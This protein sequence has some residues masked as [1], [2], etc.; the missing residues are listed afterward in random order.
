MSEQF[1]GDYAPGLYDEEKRYYLLQAQ[2][3]ATLTDAELR[4]MHYISNTYA[5]RIIQ[6]QIGDCSIN[7]GF[8]IVENTD[9]SNNFKIT[10]G[11]DT[12]DN[13]GV[14]FLKGYRLF[15]KDDITYKGQD[16][17]G[18]I[19]D[20]GYTETI[21]SPLTTPTGTVN[22]L[23]AVDVAGGNIVSCGGLET[24]IKSSD[25]GQNWGVKVSG[26]VTLFDIDMA[27]SSTGFAV[28]ENGSVQKTVNGGETWSNIGINTPYQ[29]TDSSGVSF[30]NQN[31]GW[32]VGESG[33]VL[34]TTNGGSLW[35]L[36]ASGVTSENLRDADAVDSSNIWAVGT[37]GEIIYSDDGSTWAQQSS[38]VSVDLNRAEAVDA[39][40]AY[41]AG[42]SGTIIK[43]SNSGLAWSQ[44]TPDTSENLFGL[45]FSDRNIGWAAGDNGILTHTEDGGSNWDST[46]IESGTDFRSVIFSDTTG[47]IV[48]ENGVVFRT[49]NGTNW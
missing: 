33:I 37:N 29:S 8:K 2:E 7:E 32:I 1:K 35:T 28:G 27:D 40:V 6:S 31:I 5:R 20:D 13:P 4:D 42:D 43:T 3:L 12:L 44:Q 24:I 49:L 46:V 48:G 36:Q 34:R 26:S 30:S 16:S 22:D 15:L 45:Y 10:G 11:D 14:Y 39:T 18:N 47:F 25:S 23:N 38:G 9:S 21:L 41:V 17:S 19:T